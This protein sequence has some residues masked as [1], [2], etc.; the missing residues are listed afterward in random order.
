MGRFT[1]HPD[2]Y[3]PRAVTILDLQPPKTRLGRRTVSGLLAAFAGEL[4]RRHADKI[5][6][7]TRSAL[8]SDASIAHESKG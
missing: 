6:Q 7:A 5:A 3:S 1:T 4:F 2:G 8:D